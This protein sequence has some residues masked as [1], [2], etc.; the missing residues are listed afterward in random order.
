MFQLNKGG[1]EQGIISR[2][3]CEYM[4]KEEHMPEKW[5]EGG[6]ELLMWCQEG[7]SL[8]V[9][10]QSIATM[11]SAH[12]PNF[13]W[14]ISLDLYDNIMNYYQSY[15]PIFNCEYVTIFITFYY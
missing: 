1:K 5:F 14:I 10:R 3:L 13:A 9:R 8:S 4:I 2:E 6:T 7:F 11:G 12:G 15:N